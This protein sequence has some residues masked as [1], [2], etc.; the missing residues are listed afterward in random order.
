VTGI[1]N[2]VRD[3]WVISYSQ[4]SIW[5]LVNIETSRIV[6]ATPK[7]MRHLVGKLLWELPVNQINRLEY[8]GTRTFQFEERDFSQK[9]RRVK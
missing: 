7:R 2:V 9:I 6:F 3:Q 8:K 5:L 1:T 4:T